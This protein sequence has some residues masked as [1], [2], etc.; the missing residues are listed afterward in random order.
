MESVFVSPAVVV[1]ADDFAVEPEIGLERQADV[2]QSLEEFKVD[3]VGGVKSETVDSELLNPEF[4]RAD[5]V[6]ADRLIVEV[7][8]YEV[9]VTCPALIAEAVVVVVVAPEVEVHKPRAV[10]TALAVLLNVLERE[11]IASDVVE[12]SVE[13]YSYSVLVEL[14]AYFLK[15]I[16]IAETAVDFVIIDC[17]VAVAGTLKNRV[18]NKGVNPELLEIIHPVVDFVE[19]VLELEVVLTRRSRKT[20]GIDVVHYTFVNPICHLL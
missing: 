10:L 4:N 3:T 2:S 5:K 20:E 8:L 7:E 11:E 15:R 18:E 14:V 16:I 13:D 1:A 12:N 6:V 9:D 17:V 19:A